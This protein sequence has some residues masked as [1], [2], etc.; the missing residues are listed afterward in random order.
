MVCGHTTV[1]RESYLC[2]THRY[3]TDKCTGVGLCVGVWG[4]VGVPFL[5]YRVPH[6]VAVRVL[7]IRARRTRRYISCC[8][9][10]SDEQMVTSSGDMSCG[11]FDIPS[12]Q[13][14]K[15]F[16]GHGGDVMF[17]SLGPT[18]TTYCLCARVCHG[19][20]PWSVECCAHLRLMC[21]QVISP[22]LQHM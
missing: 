17:L 16:L 13:R 4:Y 6:A 9:F 15:T 21:S 5:S 19:L 18:R 8:R 22:R 12:G 20:H 7:R 2:R 1:L 11:L 10:L 14:I 3:R